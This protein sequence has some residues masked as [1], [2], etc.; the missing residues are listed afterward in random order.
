MSFNEVLA[1]IKV[2]NSLEMTPTLED[3][4]SQSIIPFYIKKS[5]VNFMIKLIWENW[6]RQMIV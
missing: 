3:K 4:K 5:E 2:R 1:P 6:F